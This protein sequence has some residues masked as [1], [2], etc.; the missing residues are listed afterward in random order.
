MP[1]LQ[2]SNVADEFIKTPINITLYAVMM[3]IYQ[4]DKENFIFL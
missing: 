1:V 2:L 4:N 3:E